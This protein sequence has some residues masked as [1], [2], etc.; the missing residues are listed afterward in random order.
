MSFLYSQVKRLKLRAKE[1][2][3]TYEKYTDKAVELYNTTCK[4]ASIQVIMN[5]GVTDESGG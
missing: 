2:E 3:A 1:R 5:E 4:Y